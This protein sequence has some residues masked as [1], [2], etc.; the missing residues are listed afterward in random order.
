MTEE[1]TF[2]VIFRGDIVAGQQLT[3]V[4][5]RLKTLFKVDDTRIEQLF[6]G[7][8]EVI[9]K[10]VDQATASRYR[11]TLLKAGAQVQLRQ[12]AVGTSGSGAITAPSP[13][14]AAP[15]KPAASTEVERVG[16]SSSAYDTAI[17][18]DPSGDA[19]PEDTAGN[20]L[21][22][23]PDAPDAESGWTVAPVGEDV[24]RPDER[25]QVQSVVV[26]NVDFELA[27][28][29]ADLLKPEERVKVEV[30]EI[31]VSHLT[32]DAPEEDK[33]S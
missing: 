10:G 25:R 22:V 21:Q 6:S 19:S 20:D 29:G 2:E 5:E 30:P 17:T 18:P 12:Q 26:G 24:L 28:A 31:D 27:P 7:R 13:Q 15:V 23:T 1:T 16:E 11:D 9:K 14:P 32:V 4:K 8:P 3:A 33:I